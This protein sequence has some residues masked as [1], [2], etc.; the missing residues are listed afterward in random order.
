MSKYIPRYKWPNGYKL[1][2][3]HGSWLFAPLLPGYGNKQIVDFFERGATP[4]E[5]E[6]KAYNTIQNRG[7]NG[8]K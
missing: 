6:N 7:K 4:Q 1:E 2:P 8:T 3:F 5:A